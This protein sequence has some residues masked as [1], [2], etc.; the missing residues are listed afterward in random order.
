MITA[1]TNVIP[2]TADLS[3]LLGKLPKKTYTIDR[4]GDVPLEFEGWKVASGE[5]GD[6]PDP[7]EWDRFTVVD[8]YI[9]STRKYVATVAKGSREGRTLTF[10]YHDE[11][12]E[13][14]IDWFKETNHGRLGPATVLMLKDLDRLKLPWLRTATVERI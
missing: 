5:C 1:S 13:N 7:I 2:Q 8:L 14:V 6:A 12:I 3:T 4:S 11:S 9:T 10:E